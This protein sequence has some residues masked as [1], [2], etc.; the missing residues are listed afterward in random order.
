M[1]NI[2]Y[3]N[4]SFEASRRKIDANGFLKVKS[5]N[6]TKE[7]VACYYG[8]EIPN[9]K[10]F[11]LEANKVYHVYRP[12]IELAKA[13]ESFNN[14]PLTREHIEVETDN[15]P[16]DKIVGSLG[17]HAE[18]KS[19]YIKNSLIVYDQQDIDNIMNG[20]KKE[21]SCGYRYTPVKKDGEWHGQHYDFVMTNIIGN[22]VA[23]VKEGR[24]G[25]DVV[26][27]DEK[28]EFDNEQYNDIIE[29]KDNEMFFDKLLAK[30]EFKESEHP[31]D[32]SGRFTDKGGESGG[33]PEDYKKSVAHYSKEQHER[34]ANFYGEK[35]ATAQR[36]ANKEE[37][38]NQ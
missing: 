21:L 10:E 5:C 37:K 32:K 12:E 19:P 17:D 27:A 36:K 33:V 38:F 14:L 20:N 30:D 18:Y 7:Q 2:V 29:E 15:V 25:H 16:K 1:S 23:L 34:A 31:R 24:A 13:V 9:W 4:V 8:R 22:H 26:V 28:P 35:M 6:L 3:D 11:G